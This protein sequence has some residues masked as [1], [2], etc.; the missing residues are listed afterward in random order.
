MAMKAI[1]NVCNIAELPDPSSR[2]FQIT[3]GE[4]D[5]DAFVIHWR[6]SCYAYVNCCPHTQISL[7]WSPDQFLDIEGQYIQCGM[8]GALFRPEDGLCVHGPCVGKS[9]QGIP[10]QV[11]DGIV[12]IELKKIVEF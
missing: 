11:E 8:H 2:A 10:V 6:G 12:Q 7:N 5:I 1:W 9:L 4:L 3:T